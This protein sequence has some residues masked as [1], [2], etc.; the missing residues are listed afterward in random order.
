[1]RAH[2][3]VAPASLFDH[4]LGLLQRIEYLAAEQFVPEAAIEALAVAVF[5]DWPGFDVG[6]LV[7]NGGD[8]VPDRFSD[9]T[10]M[11]TCE[12]AGFV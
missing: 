7:A 8:S 4:G 5:P 10:V 3:I 2:R 6:G 11:G 9:G 1:M 12:R